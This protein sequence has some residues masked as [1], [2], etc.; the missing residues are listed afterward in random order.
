VV[1]IRHR[2]AVLTDLETSGAIKIAGAMYDLET[3][4]VEFFA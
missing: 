3:G 4:R 1:D 2:S